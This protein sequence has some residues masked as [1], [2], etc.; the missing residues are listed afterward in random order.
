MITAETALL[1]L[2]EYEQL[3]ENGIRTELVRGRVV[4]MNPPFP[5]HGF[6]CSKVDRIIGGFVEANDRGYAMCNDSGVV[7]E[8]MPHVRSISVG[9]WIGTGSREETLEEEIRIP[10]AKK[11]YYN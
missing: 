9:V 7:T 4:P 1:T 3:P 6:V 11:K 5:Y 2:Q 10:G 8:R